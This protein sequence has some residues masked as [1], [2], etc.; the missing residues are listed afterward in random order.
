MA[1]FEETGSTFWKWLQ[2]NG[3]TLSK[4]IAIKDYRSE[5]AGR[6]VIAANDI[7]EGELLFSLPRS[8]LLSPFTSSL[9]QVDGLKD[10]LAALNG[11]TPLIVTLMYESQKEDSFWKP[12]FDVLPRQ[13]STPMFWEEADLEELRGTDIVSKLGKAEAEET[14]ENEVNPIIEKYPNLF[15]KNVHNLE[16]FHT[17]GSLIM[18]YSF[19]DELQKQQGESNANEKENDD[20]EEQDS[21]EEEKEE[22][23]EEEQ[24]VITMVPM[25]DMLNHRTGFNNARLFHESDSLQMKAIKDIKQGEQIYNTYGDLCNADLLRKYGFTDEKNEFDLVELDGPLIVEHCNVDQKQDEEL[26]ERKID[27][28]MEEGV[29]DECFVIDTEHEI[30]LE[31]IV[32]VHVL[33]STPSEFE[34]M[35]E[36][37]KLPKPRLTQDVK[38]IILNILKKRLSRYPT[39]V[40]EDKQALKDAT[41]SKRNALLVRMGEKNII[42]STIQTLSAAPVVAAA[43]TPD[44]RSSNAK[45]DHGKSKKQKRH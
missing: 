6:G 44:K 22:E 35:E 30:P 36:K 10:D 11:W 13:F 37:Q 18:A 23:E 27:F 17:C 16:L 25:A 26:I 14:F 24:Q 3:A 9:N 5:G 29:L 38:Q 8:I 7:K 19:N 15:D 34:K 31:L 2:D 45:N 4:D 32:S 40:E 21:D 43:T 28:L 42:E 1:S 41:G 12:Y 20:H 39:T 33:C